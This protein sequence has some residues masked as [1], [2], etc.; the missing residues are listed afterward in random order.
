MKDNKKESGSHIINIE[1]IRYCDEWNIWH[2]D[3]LNDKHDVSEVIKYID[4]VC[5]DHINYKEIKNKRQ[6]I[7]HSI[8]HTIE[9]YKRYK[10]NFR[11][12]NR[13]MPSRIGIY[14]TH[15]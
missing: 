4:L 5:Q 11:I 13:Q 7:S 1:V 3:E 2:R 14:S 15:S 12:K 8:Q 10:P 9:G 6:V